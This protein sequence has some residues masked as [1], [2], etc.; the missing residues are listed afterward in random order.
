MTKIS[1]TTTPQA[2][3]QPAPAGMA[4][5]ETHA[6]P[7]APTVP[8]GGASLE[9]QLAPL[10]IAA[11]DPMVGAQIDPAVLEK[12]SGVLDGQPAGAVAAPGEIEIDLEP[13]A[14]T[15]ISLNADVLAAA[16]AE[17]AE[18]AAAFATLTGGLAK[19]MSEAQ[20]KDPL[21]A[22]LQNNE[23]LSSTV[24]DILNAAL[25]EPPAPPNAPML[26]V[27]QSA[28]QFKA[29]PS[30][31]TWLG[32]KA[33]SGPTRV[34]PQPDSGAKVK[35]A[36][37][38][39]EAL[40]NGAHEYLGHGNK[41]DAHK[42]VTQGWEGAV[43]AGLPKGDIHAIVQ[44]VLRESYLDTLQDM[45]FYADKVRFF[46]ETK[47]AIR[48]ELKEANAAFAGMAGQ[49]DDATL[50]PPF[51]AKQFD[52][53]YTPGASPKV[54][55]SR[56]TTETKKQADSPARSKGDDG[57]ANEPTTRDVDLPDKKT[58]YDINKY[59]TKK[60]QTASNLKSRANTYTNEFRAWFD[61]Q[62]PEVQAEIIKKM[63]AGDYSFKTKVDYR[64]KKD[65]TKTLNEPMP[66]GMHPADWLGQRLGPMCDGMAKSCAKAKNMSFNFNVDGTVKI[67]IDGGGSSTA[68]GIGQSRHGAQAEPWTEGKACTTKADLQ[69]YIEHLETTL[70]QIGDDAQLANVDLQNATQKQQQLI[71]MMSNLSKSLH[72]T[73]LAVIRKIGG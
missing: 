40:G 48:A 18:Q 62:P 34:S 24:E 5:A 26:F 28:L 15:W 12:L 23:A 59:A 32:P 64:G 2:Y 22:E 42:Q 57:K 60:S 7:D 47:R 41:V 71:Q 19:Q 55:E 29:P 30:G 8:A 65:V 3:L 33:D 66:P 9:G 6:Q 27:S 37:S 36:S 63:E 11:R 72:D 56:A 38:N 68:G 43:Q 52:T 35:R 16:V 4:A 67:P 13:G 25:E 46:N 69:A 21:F 58:T 73:A 61:G 39:K 10:M 14:P 51:A 54:E 1:N 44:W 53:T 17:D 31:P 50:D 49:A 45:A 20:Q 70:Q